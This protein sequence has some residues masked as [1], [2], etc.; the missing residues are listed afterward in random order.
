MP[1]RASWRGIFNPR[2]TT[3]TIGTRCRLRCCS[4]ATS[5]GGR[6]I[7]SVFYLTS[8]GKPEGWAGRDRA[9]WSHSTLEAIDYKTGKLR[10]TRDLGEGDGHAGILTTAGKLLF[11]ADNDG[12]LLAL[13]PSTG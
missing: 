13:D 5:V 7:G 1:T 3:R 10:W 9:V 4:T 6:D 12:N 2:R 11:T 8:T